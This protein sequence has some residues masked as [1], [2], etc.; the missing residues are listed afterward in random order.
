MIIPSLVSEV[1]DELEEE[2]KIFFWF[3]LFLM[4]LCIV[5]MLHADY[6]DGF[7]F[8]E[9]NVERETSPRKTTIRHVFWGNALE[10]L[11]EK[12]KD[13][14]KD[15]GKTKPGYDNKYTHEDEGELWEHFRNTNEQQK[16][17]EWHPWTRQ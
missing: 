6:V 7:Q 8:G 2:V 4:L 12:T 5:N 11:G 10:I 1:V 16:D 15:D 17:K 13:K 3:D 14:D 9:L